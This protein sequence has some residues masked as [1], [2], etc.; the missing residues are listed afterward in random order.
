MRS[1]GT[2]YSFHKSEAEKSLS[3][4]ISVARRRH[5]RSIDHSVSMPARPV[6]PPR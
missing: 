6:T 2:R 3:T 1:A 4:W 5:A